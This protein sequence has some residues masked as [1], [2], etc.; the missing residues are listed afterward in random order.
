MVT[1]FATLITGTAIALFGA[2][3]EA[4]VPNPLEGNNGSS[5]QLRAL[6]ID[7][8]PFLLRCDARSHTDRN[9][10]SEM[11]PHPDGVQSMFSADFNFLDEKPDAGTCE[12]PVP[13]LQGSRTVARQ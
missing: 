8:M 12:I 9:R 6:T 3:A 13:S 11:L 1:N 2:M 7:Q 4:N 10:S 5:E